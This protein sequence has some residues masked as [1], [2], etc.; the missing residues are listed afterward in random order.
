MNERKSSVVLVF[1]DK[2]ELALQLRAATDTS[3]PSHW[4]FSAAGGIKDG[5]DP[6]DA[7]NRELE[8]EIGIHG[9][10]EPVGEVSYVDE[11][12]ED[13]LYIYKMRHNGSFNLDPNE[14]DDE[15]FFALAVIASM[16]QAGEKFHPEFIFVW[17]KGVIQ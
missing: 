10:L 15:R 4:D 2:N 1:N 17:N 8:E 5:E 16:I 6:L 11:R 12:G 3:Y 13:Y 9:K 14:V 7:A